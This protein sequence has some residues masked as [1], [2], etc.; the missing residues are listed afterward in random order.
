MSLVIDTLQ[1]KVSTSMNHDLLQPYLREEV[2]ANLFQMQSMKAPSLDG[3]PTVFCSK[4]LDYSGG[5]CQSNVG[6]SL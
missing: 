1:P 6:L 4:I 2:R 3:M 5:C